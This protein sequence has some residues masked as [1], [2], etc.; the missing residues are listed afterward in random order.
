[1]LLIRQSFPLLCLALF[2]PM[3]GCAS[4]MS[5]GPDKVSFK[6]EPSGAAVSIDG[7]PVGQTPVTTDV[8]RTAKYA[9][10][11]LPGYEETQLP[12][13]RKENPWV[14]GNQAVGGI[15]GEMVDSANTNN[16]MAN[17]E[18]TAHLHHSLHPANP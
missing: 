10:F 11:S 12:I 3:T 2:L 8:A 9:T 1:M 18:M 7:K 16:L 14:Y 15:T 6:S 4:I 5:P 17:S 13:S